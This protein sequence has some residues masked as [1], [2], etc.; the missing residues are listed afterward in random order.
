[1]S[2]IR[3]HIIN[4]GLS[5]GRQSPAQYTHCVTLG[6]MYAN[7]LQAPPTAAGFRTLV[8]D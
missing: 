1:M 5:L 6:A 7:A 2:L 3:N 8:S 4:I